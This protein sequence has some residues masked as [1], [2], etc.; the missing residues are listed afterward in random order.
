MPH[1]S[2]DDPAEFLDPDEF[3]V[4]AVIQFQ[5]G[6]TRNIVGMY[7]G[8]YREGQLGEYEQDT[9]K[10]KFTCA[11][12]VALGAKRGDGLVVYQADGKTVFGTFGI[13]TYPQPD[14]TGLEVLELSPE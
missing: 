14:G 10:P 2:W 13:L 12:G 5:D 1:P 6:T 8:P 3:A 4:K 9:T 7:D 11:E